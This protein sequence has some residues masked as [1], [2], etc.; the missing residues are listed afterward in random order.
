[1]NKKQQKALDNLI[2]VVLDP[3]TG[4]KAQG[5]KIN[6]VVDGMEVNG[7][8]GIHNILKG[9]EAKLETVRANVSD[10]IIL[11]ASQ[12]SSRNFA[13][14]F[15]ELAK[16]RPIR[17]KILKGVL[18]FVTSGTIITIIFKLFKLI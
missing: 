3:K 16:A 14:A 11:T 6:F 9:Q 18:G 17:I 5:E 1:M 15:R 2:T 13:I 7:W 12:R 10:L 8:K 4:L